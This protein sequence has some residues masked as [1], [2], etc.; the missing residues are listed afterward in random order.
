M[1]CYVCGLEAGRTPLGFTVYRHPECAPGT[2]RWAEWYVASGRRSE[3]GDR[4]LK[5]LQAKKGVS[6]NA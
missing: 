6:N 3:A 4:L 1:K 5:H 2:E